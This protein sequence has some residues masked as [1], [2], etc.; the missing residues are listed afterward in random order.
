MGE[1][2]LSVGVVA[3]SFGV[4]IWNNCMVVQI[5]WNVIGVFVRAGALECLLGG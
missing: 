4:V 2:V 3:W 5:I 1:V